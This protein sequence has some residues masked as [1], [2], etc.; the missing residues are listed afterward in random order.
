MK[1]SLNHTLQ[2]LHI[3]SSVQS[4]TLQLTTLHC[5]IDSFPWRLCVLDSRLLSCDSS[6][7]QVKVTLRLTVSQSVSLGVEPHLGYMTVYLLLFD[8]Y[9]LVF[10]GRP[11]WRENGFV[12]CICCRLLPAQFSQVRVPWD[13]RPYFILSDLRLL[14]SA[15]PTTRR[16]TVEVF[17]SFLHTGISNLLANNFCCPL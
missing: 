3:K 14:F 6:L 10:V 13:S 11:L 9:G 4:R 7:S 8:S 17:D 15:P 5:T 1:A 16:V 2:I 12:F